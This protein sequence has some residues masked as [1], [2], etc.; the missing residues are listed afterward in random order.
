MR[1]CLQEIGRLKSEAAR[2]GW[3]SERAGSALTV[4]RIGSAVAMGRNIAQTPMVNGAAAREG[5]LAVRKGILGRDRVVVSAPTTFDAIERYGTDRN[6]VVADLGKSLLAFSAVRYARNG[7]IDAAGLNR[8]LENS[9]ATLQKL[10]FNTMWP[11]RNLQSIR[12]SMW[13][14]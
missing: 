6:P 5:Q 7:T 12:S 2:S 11:V 14:R 13:T 9:R 10:R 3:T 4:L 1:A 8:A